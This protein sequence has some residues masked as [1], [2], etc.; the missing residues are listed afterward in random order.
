MQLAFLHNQDPD[1]CQGADALSAL[2]LG[3]PRNS[4]QEVDVSALDTSHALATFR[5]TRAGL[6]VL[7]FSCR[8]SGCSTPAVQHSTFV[9]A[10]AARALMNCVCCQLTGTHS[11]AG[12]AVSIV[13]MLQ[14]PAVLKSLAHLSVEP[15]C[16]LSKQ[17]CSTDLCG[18]A[19]NVA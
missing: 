7:Q 9:T 1:L 10:G 3:I 12:C 8:A 14:H 6:A 15:G 16:S 5:S 19:S 2:V 11:Q 4:S 18:G 13:H 17:R